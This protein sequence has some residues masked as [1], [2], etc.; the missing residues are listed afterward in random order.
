MDKFLGQG[1]AAS[2][3]LR[4]GGIDQNNFRHTKDFIKG[5]GAKIAAGLT[6]IAALGTAVIFGL[7]FLFGKPG[8]K[9][10]GGDSHHGNRQ[11]Y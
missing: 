9:G 1:M 7:D 2:K 3:Q 6:C 10:N 8:G 5:P 4:N 11:R